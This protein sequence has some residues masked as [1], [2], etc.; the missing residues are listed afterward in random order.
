M[1]LTERGQREVGNSLRDA[2]SRLRRRRA[3]LQEKMGILE[4][5]I[6]DLGKLEASLMYAAELVA[7]TEK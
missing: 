4:V 7:K 6:A 3:D 5:E 2:L 1:N